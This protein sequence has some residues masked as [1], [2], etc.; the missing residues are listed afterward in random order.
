MN[1][2]PFTRNGR[3]VLCAALLVLSSG[4]AARGQEPRK[5]SLKETV[6]LAVRNSRDVALAS[7]QYT[8]A[9]AAVGVDRSVFLP[10]LYTGSGA[11]YTYGFPTTPG[12]T[13]PALFNLSYTE[14]LYNAPAHGEMRA[15]EDRAEG[16]HFDL[17]KRA[18][19]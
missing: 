15:A 14:S 10:N 11:A 7:A 5:L 16:K 12:G 2:P 19:W 8:A 4:G 3:G 6:T 17:E 13:P 9:K 18:T 1:K